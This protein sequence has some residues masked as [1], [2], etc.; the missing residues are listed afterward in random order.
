MNRRRTLVAVGG[1]PGT[2]KTTLLRKYME[3]GD[4]SLCHP[5]KLVSAMYNPEKS[6][7]ILGKYEEGETFAG[8]D[9]LSMAAQPAVQNWVQS[10]HCNVLFEGD[11][12]FNLSFI[13][14]AM[15]LPDNRCAD[16]LPEGSPADPGGTLSGTGVA[17]IR[18]VLE[19]AG[20]E[21]Q[22]PAVKRG[23]CAAHRRVRKYER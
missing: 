23:P 21:V 20:H 2:G 14:F 1:S 18:A 6:L 19:R 13:K 4:W 8:T 3:G 15:G 17:P 11:R 10:H 22:E 7:Y 5:A 16:C 9:R 12:C